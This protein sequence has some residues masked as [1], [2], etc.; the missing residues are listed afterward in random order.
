MSR[1]SSIPCTVPSSPPL[2]CSAIKTTS[3][4][5]AKVSAE[6]VGTISSEAAS[7]LCPI[8]G[9]GACARV[10]RSAVSTPRMAY[11]MGSSACK[12]ILPVARETGRSLEAPP[13]STATRNFRSNKLTLLR[14]APVRVGRTPRLIANIPRSQKHDQVAGTDERRQHLGN[15]PLLRQIEGLRLRMEHARFLG[16]VRRVDS[17]QGGFPCRIDIR[18]QEHVRLR[19]HFRKLR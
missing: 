5:P 12:I 19:K 7:P 3:G 6:A 9:A 14:S 2:P 17:G 16:D 18:D 13:I 10:S 1:N 11:F 4:R 15:V 8:R